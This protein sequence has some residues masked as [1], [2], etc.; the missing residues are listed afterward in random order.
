M[1]LATA[2]FSKA[3]AHMEYAPVAGN[4]RLFTAG[5][6][7]RV[8]DPV[9]GVGFGINGG[10][11]MGYLVGDKVSTPETTRSDGGA[12]GLSAA[13]FGFDIVVLNSGCGEELGFGLNPAHTTTDGQV[14]NHGEQVLRKA[15]GWG[16]ELGGNN[17][18]C[19]WHLEV[20]EIY[21]NRTVGIRWDKKQSGS[22]Q[23]GLHVGAGF[24]EFLQTPRGRGFSLLAFYSRFKYFTN[25]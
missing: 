21:E 5:S 12:Q 13:A 19:M 20:E 22:M 14:L 11:M 17:G 23:R 2:T 10:R 3:D 4:T 9:E 1:R 8:P 6:E 25:V 18:V 7:T 24:R 16:S 15:D